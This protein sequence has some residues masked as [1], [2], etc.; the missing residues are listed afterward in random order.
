MQRERK[1]GVLMHISSLP[2]GYSIG[3]L[4]ASAYKFID[5]LSAAGFSYWQVLPLTVTD[6]YNSPYKSRGF[7]TLNPFFIDLE[8]LFSEGLITS[9]EL[10]SAHEHSP[11]LVEYDRLWGSRLGLLHS[12][13]KRYGD[14]ESVRAFIAQRPHLARAA[15]FLALSDTA[16]ALRGR[17]DALDAEALYLWQF[18]HYVFFKQW[19]ALKSYANA[20]GVEIIGDLPMYADYDSSDVYFNPECFMLDGSCEMLAVAGVPPDSFSK[21]GQLWGNP[22]YN[23]DYIKNTGFALWRER[24]FVSIEMFDALRLDHFRA[25]ESFY[26]IPNG[27]PNACAGKWQPGPR[28]D[29]VRAFSRFVGNKAVIAEDLGGISKE[30]DSL[31]GLGGFYN[32]RIVQFGFSDGG[33]HLSHSFN[34]RTFAYTGTHDN[35]TLLGYIFGADE[36][37]R[38][39]LFDYYGIHH[40]NFELAAFDIIEATMRS[41]AAAVIL[42]VQ[43]LLLFGDDTRMNVPGTA[44]GNWRFRLTAAALN[45]LCENSGKWKNINL[46]FRR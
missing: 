25:I 40:Q 42:P 29:F 44:E 11:Y 35:N 19:M 20:R 45:V 2:S 33:A 24:A 36:G 28:E 15:Y 31:E 38:V 46:K 4:G 30:V 5:F 32:T 21:E 34:A 8:T 6:K 1:S 43:D 10:N 26:S 23:W 41:S 27:A 37:E 39:K 22:L 18:L 14:K 13:A 17:C 7:F 9:A 12:A 3:G 16:G